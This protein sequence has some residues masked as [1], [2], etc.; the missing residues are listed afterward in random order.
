MA[1]CKAPSSKLTAGDRKLLRAATIRRRRELNLTPDGW[2]IPLTVC[3]GT[4]RRWF[5]DSQT[6][7]D[8][9]LP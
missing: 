2:R 8:G 7:F 4:V 1:D 9:A 5:P 6:D 3:T